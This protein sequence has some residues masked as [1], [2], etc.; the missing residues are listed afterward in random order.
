M[1]A[2]NT[3]AFG[4]GEGGRILGYNTDGLEVSNP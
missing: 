2:V 3:V 1:G 4:E